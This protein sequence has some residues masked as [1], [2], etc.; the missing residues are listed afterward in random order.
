M[1]ALS[2]SADFVISSFFLMIDP[3]DF[4]ASLLAETERTTTMFEDRYKRFIPA[5]DKHTTLLR[6]SSGS[7]R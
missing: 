6:E 5:G 3:V 1:S 7:A 2:S 4:T